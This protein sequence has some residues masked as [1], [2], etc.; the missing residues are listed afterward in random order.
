LECLLGV[1]KVSVLQGN[2]TTAPMTDTP[3][4]IAINRKSH[5]QWARLNNAPLTR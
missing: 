2:N 5:L 1:V 4:K 3:A